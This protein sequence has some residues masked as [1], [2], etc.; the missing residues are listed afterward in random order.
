MAGIHV[1]VHS[2][3]RGLGIAADYYKRFPWEPSPAGDL[4]LKDAKIVTIDKMT[5]DQLLV[6]LGNAPAGGTVLIVCHAHD[7]HGS[8]S[9]SSGL[10]M[11]LAADAGVSAQ[12]DAFQRLLEASAANRKANTIRA[13]PSKTDAEKKAKSDQWIGLATEFKLG[14]P[15]DGA[16]LPKLEQFF[17]NGLQSLALRELHLRGGATSLKRMLGHID[18]VQSLKLERVE[19]RACKIGKDTGTL[20][21][22]KALFGC[23]RLLA[24]VART[25]Y[26][27]RMP[28]DNL[29]RFDQRY[30]AEHRVGQFRPPGPAGRSYRDPVDFV[31][32]VIRT[33]PSSRIFWDVEFG[34][35]PAANPHPA[36]NKYDGGTSTI[37]LKG[38]VLA[39]LVEE[40]SHSWYR[41]SAATWH[42]TSARKPVWD[43]ARKFV[44]EYMMKQSTY[45]TGPLMISGFWTPDEEVPWLLPNEPDY[46]DHITQV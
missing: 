25:F 20:G 14:F 38:R 19:F 31:T 4:D 2:G 33:N 32:D 43:D 28:V 41:G 24:P 34:Y 9:Q 40:V 11:P 18:K 45:S 7:E 35:I 15:P 10:L 16:T 39:M 3:E 26:L 1:I 30:I 13:M 44:Q 46:I 22:L 17:E 36:P 42:E 12:D 27:D 6:E 29:D 37:K 21:N 23:R 5:F 8:L